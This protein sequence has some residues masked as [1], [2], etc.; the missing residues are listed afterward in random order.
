MAQENKLFDQVRNMYT[1]ETQVDSNTK[2]ESMYMLIRLLSLSPAGFF[3]AVES[4][5][6]IGAP[7]W[8]KLMHL[9]RS[10]PKQAA[11]RVKYP[12]AEKEKITPKRKMALEKVCKLFC[13]G[14]EHAFQIMALLEHQG[15]VLEA[16]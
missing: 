8:A 5:R 2:I 15:V 7:D 11:P 12:K 9:Y 10:I 16:D 3:A 4:N 1:K 14:E 6:M 13:V